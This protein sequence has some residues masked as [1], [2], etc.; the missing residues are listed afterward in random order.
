MSN[1]ALTK[2]STAALGLLCRTAG[3][4]QLLL[5]QPAREL[6][7][8]ITVEPIGTADQRGQIEAVLHLREQ[9]HSITLQR[10]D[11]ANAQHLAEWVEAAANGTLDT[12]A[13]IP[14]RNALLP[15]CKCGSAAIGYDY[16]IPGSEF[17]NGVKCRHS[18][19]QSVEGAETPEAAHE[20]WNAIQREDLDEQPDHADDMVNHPPHYTG[21]PSGVEC[22][23]VAELLPFTLGNAFRYVF[24]HQQKG[25]TED[26]RKA[27]WYLQRDWSREAGQAI[28][29][30]DLQLARTAA[31]RIAAHESYVL[32]GCLVAIASYELALAIDLLD[33][34]IEAA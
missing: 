15:C 3:T 13:A 34:L 1:F 28:G 4:D 6:R 5:I 29:I 33:R 8:E 18:G 14:Q 19:C 24:R 7:A 17:R 22:I 27:R 9:R 21:H 32:G 11:G 23:E 30:G 25:G 20:A 26:L 10:D 2:A 16:A 31:M 12:A